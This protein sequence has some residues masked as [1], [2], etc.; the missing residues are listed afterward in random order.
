MQN[1][2][3]SFEKRI[4]LLQNK[5]PLMSRSLRVSKEP[6]QLGQ[7]ENTI[8]VIDTVNV[9][10]TAVSAQTPNIEQKFTS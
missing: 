2:T 6:L 1:I 4:K 10:N 5:M 3:S 9:R 8:T 7:L